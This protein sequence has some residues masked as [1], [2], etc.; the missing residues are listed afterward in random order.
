M[1]P[2]RLFLLGDD[3]SFYLRLVRDLFFLVGCWGRFGKYGNSQ[4][5]S[6][7][8]DCTLFFW[9][10]RNNGVYERRGVP[11]GHRLLSTNVRLGFLFS[12]GGSP[13]RLLPSGSSLMAW[14]SSQWMGIDPLGFRSSKTCR[15]LDSL[16]TC[17][18]PKRQNHHF[19]AHLTGARAYENLPVVHSFFSGGWHCG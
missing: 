17:L 19:L 4:C 3:Q 6:F 9:R 13:G 16:Y 7:L 11:V 12:L 14:T 1:S 18:N 8:S 15:Y 5:C 10:F 2:H